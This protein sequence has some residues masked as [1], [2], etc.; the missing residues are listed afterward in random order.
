MTSVPLALGKGRFLVL[1]PSF[2]AWDLG[3]YLLRLFRAARLSATGFPFRAYP[4]PA[5]AGEALLER[6]RA[7]RTDVIIGLNLDGIEPEILGE[8]RRLGARLI[9]WY[10]DCYTSRIPAWLPPRLEHLDLF[11]TTAK[12]MVPAYRAATTTPVEWLLEGA[13][14]PAFPALSVSPAA[15]RVY[16]SDV[17]FV[18]SVLHPPVRDRRLAGHRRRLLSRLSRRHRVTVW[19]PQRRPGGPR[20]LG[21][22]RCRVIRWP[23]YHEELVKVCHASYVVLGINTVN[24]IELYFSN[25]TFLTLAAGGFHLTHYVPGLEMLFENHRHLVWFESDDECLDLCRHYLAR[26]AAR[27][28][29]AAAGQAWVRRRFGMARQFAQLLELTARHAPPARRRLVAGRP[30]A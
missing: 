21:I 7:E 25:R 30:G 17:A 6:L 8:I 14:L 16:G 4:T 22:P 28:R 12:G 15:R 29:I 13:Y 2:Q 26:P 1:A 9:L 5:S 24:S 11:L 3:T 19:G 18:G 20:A 10:V 23:A 27:R